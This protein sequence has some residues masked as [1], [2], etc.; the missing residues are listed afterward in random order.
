MKSIDTSIFCIHGH[1]VHPGCCG[2]S[3]AC[4]SELKLKNQA[5]F[6]LL[7]GLLLTSQVE[8]FLQAAMQLGLSLNTPSHTQQNRVEIFSE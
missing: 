5:S 7:C 6:I 8:G 3:H 4:G 2:D 1:S